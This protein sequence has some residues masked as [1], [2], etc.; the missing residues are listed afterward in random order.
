MSATRFKVISGMCVLAGLLLAPT[1]V[2]AINYTANYMT[3]WSGCECSAN[4]LSYTDD[5][6]N[7][8]DSE[9]SSLGH[10]L[11]QKYVNGSVWASDL[12][13]DRGFAGQDYLYSDDSVFFAFAGHGAAPGSDQTF[14]VPT[15]HAGSADSCEYDSQQSRLGEKAST[16][17]ATPNPGLMRYMMW[18]TCFSVDVQ[19]NEQWGQTFRHGLDYIMGYRGTS[20]DSENTDEVP[21]DFAQEAFYYNNTFKS[22]WFY[23][24]EDWWV[25]DTGSLISAGTTEGSAIYRR[26]YLTRFTAPRSASE[27]HE[28]SAWS[29][30]AG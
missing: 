8:F 19:P 9:M 5:Q 29:Y 28:F 12:V 1:K 14:I 4:S 10:S 25:D 6:I 26:D 13:E 11:E 7:M 27:V 17:Y 3:S 21:E 23:A 18:L 15:C 30:H 16:Y 20:A 22:S 24:V 2:H